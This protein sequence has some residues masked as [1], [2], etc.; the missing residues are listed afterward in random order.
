[1]GNGAYR[2]FKYLVKLYA[3]NGDF[4]LA[5]NIEQCL[6]NHLKMSLKF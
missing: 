3:S 2:G 6:R 4:I 1:M 5:V